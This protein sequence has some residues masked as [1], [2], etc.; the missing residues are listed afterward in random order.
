[1]KHLHATIAPASV[2]RFRE[3]LNRRTL[4]ASLTDPE[5]AKVCEFLDSRTGQTFTLREAV[6]HF[7]QP[8]AVQIRLDRGDLASII[9]QDGVTVSVT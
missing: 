2:R 8:V 5:V 3:G 7:G 4:R 9:T 1:M 6:Q